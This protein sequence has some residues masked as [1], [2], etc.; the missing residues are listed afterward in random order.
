MFFRSSLF[1]IVA[2]LFV[3]VPATQ[4][5]SALFEGDW[6][7]TQVTHDPPVLNAAQ[8]PNVALSIDL[9]SGRVVI[10]ES[11]DDTAVRSFVLITDGEPRSVGPVTVQRPLQRLVE[12]RWEGNQLV[13]FRQWSRRDD[14]GQLATIVIEETWAISPGASFLDVTQRRTVGDRVVT[15][16]N[17]YSRQ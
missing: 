14:A 11:R 5:Q 17:R 9:Q 13:V 7:L 2:V 12:A 15:T 4:A 10:D 1:V 3:A 16:T 6:S 8:P